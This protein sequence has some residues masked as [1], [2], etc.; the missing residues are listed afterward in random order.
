MKIIESGFEILCPANAEE[1][2]REC[3]L[4][5]LAGRTAYKSE[6]KIT[7]DS[8]EGFLSMIVKR[9]HSA[10]IEFG[11]LVVRFVTDRGVSHELVR[12]RLCSFV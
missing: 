12:H 9:N 4:V 11:N 1:L 3:R 5:E 7:D 2:A 10:V 8:W 6:G